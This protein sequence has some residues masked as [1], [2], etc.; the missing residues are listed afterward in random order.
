MVEIETNKEIKNIKQEYVMGLGLKE[1]ILGLISVV[2]SA[3]L[4]VALP[5]YGI[6]KGYIC[7]ITVILLMFLFNFQ[8]AGMTL[9]QHL[10]CIIKS[11]GY[12]N[13]PLVY[14]N[15]IKERRKILR[16]D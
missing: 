6:I 2:I 3:V 9:F 8:I 11:L 16:N 7:M 10:M 5:F 12:I 14:K 4:Y 13:K 15:E 1:I